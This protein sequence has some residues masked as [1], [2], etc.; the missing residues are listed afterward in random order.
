MIVPGVRESSKAA[1][2]RMRELI[3]RSVGVDLIA[4]AERAERG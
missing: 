1:V 3:A 4:K 2:N